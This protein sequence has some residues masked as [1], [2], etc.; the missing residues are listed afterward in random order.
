M[1]LTDHPVMCCGKELKSIEERIDFLM[2]MTKAY[3]LLEKFLEKQ[4]FVDINIVNNYR[5]KYKLNKKE[6][7][8]NIVRID[9]YWTGGKYYG[10]KK[11]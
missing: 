7:Y 11:N 10:K 9:L 3:F 8:E 6:M 1:K 4:N 5:T 2:D